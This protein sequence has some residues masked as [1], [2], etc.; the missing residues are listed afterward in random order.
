M[1][2][3]QAGEFELEEEDD[4][5]LRRFPKKMSGPCVQCLPSREDAADSKHARLNI[6]F[7]DCYVALCPRHEGELLVV[8]LR[9][10]IR[11]RDKKS[12]SGFCGPLTKPTPE[13]INQD[14]EDDELEMTFYSGEFE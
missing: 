11:R 10:Y 5:I 1:S 9:N 4:I 12:R 14:M 6:E 3:E 8:L 7:R 13:E 2:T